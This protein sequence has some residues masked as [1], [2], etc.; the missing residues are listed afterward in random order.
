[1]LLVQTP[2]SQLMKLSILVEH[3]FEHKHMD[4]EISVIDF[5]AMHYAKGDV[6]DADHDRDMQLP[7]KHFSSTSLI[8]TFFQ[9]PVFSIAE[10]IFIAGTMKQTLL[11]KSPHHSSESLSNIWQPPKQ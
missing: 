2:I 7:F 4:T 9:S 1:M 6:K 10:K 3:Y 11:Y 5:L 8:F